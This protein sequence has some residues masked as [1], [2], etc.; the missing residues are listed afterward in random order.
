VVEFETLL[1][2]LDVQGCTRDQWDRFKTIIAIATLEASDIESG[3]A[4]YHKARA[5]WRLSR[6]YDGED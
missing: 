2:A 6:F 4:G 1:M 5:K 3:T